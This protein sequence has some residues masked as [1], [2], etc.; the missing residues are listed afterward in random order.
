MALDAEI[1]GRVRQLAPTQENLAQGDDAMLSINTRAD[2]LV[3]QALPPLAE[4]VRM[5]RSFM[6]VQTSA[7]APVVALPTT[8]A[9][10]SLYNAEPAGGRVY[11]IDSVFVICVVSAGAATGIGVTV[12][13]NLGR[14]TTAPA[15][16]LTPKGLA[17][18]AY[19]GKGIVALAIGSLTDDSWHVAG[20][21]NVGPASQIGLCVDVPLKGLYAVPPAGGYFHMAV[22]ANTV[23][24]ITVRMGIRWHEVQTSIG[25]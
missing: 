11:F 6:A 8:T 2:L 5:G 21:T 16:G 7:V 20:S 18:N 1:L 15:V 3:A 13:N 25:P 17:G 14:V 24:T 9:Q 23:T 19:N 10:V 4:I 12:M 22:M